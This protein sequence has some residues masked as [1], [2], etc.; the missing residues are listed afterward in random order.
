[1]A[2]AN[3][4]IVNGE[5]ILDLRSDTVTS[6]TLQK[7]Y[8][9]H[10]K[11]GTKIT[12]TLEVPATEEQTVEL[13]MLSGNQVIQPTNGKVMSKVTVQKPDT[14]L[15][16]NIKKGVVI[17]GVTGTL[18][19]GGTRETWVI[20]S[21]ASGVFATTQIAFTSN[22]QNFTS[23]G[24]NYDDTGSVIILHYDNNEIAGYDPG[25]GSG[26]EFENEAYRKLTF[27]TSPA[28]ALLTWLQSNATKQPD[29]TAVLDT[30]ALTITS[31]GPV[32]VTP[33][34]PYDALKKVDVTVNVASGGGGGA[35]FKVTF[36]ATATNWANV[37]AAYLLLSDGTVK[38]FKSYSAVSGQTIENVAGIL[39]RNYDPFYVLRMTLSAGGIAQLYVEENTA[40]NV[41]T[42]APNSTV[43]PYNGG[44]NLFWWPVADTVISAIE[45]YNTD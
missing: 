13:S 12:G 26:F 18:E 32:S 9:A 19:A 4:V 41:V 16:E 3:E 20:K 34:A 10:D 7:G 1:M 37:I 43:T 31:N 15:P 39:V 2:N 33:D 45:M 22:G 23:I 6:K 29:D 40:S 8:T 36:P 42:T 24:A 30:K 28:G 35:G 27:D 5:T 14:L 25:A 38:S 17:G 44:H 11:S 21:D